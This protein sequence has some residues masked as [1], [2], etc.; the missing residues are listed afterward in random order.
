[1]YM[2]FNT[3]QQW[4][5]YKL[6]KLFKI[7]TKQNKRIKLAEITKLDGNKN[8]KRKKKSFNHL[9]PCKVC[10]PMSNALGKKI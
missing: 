2:P 1:M 6:L 8:K 7:K 4:A 5:V 3:Q 9:C 10:G